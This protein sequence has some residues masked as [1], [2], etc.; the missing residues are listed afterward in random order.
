MYPTI[1]VLILTARVTAK[2]TAVI[3]AAVATCLGSRDCFCTVDLLTWSSYYNH[4][5]NP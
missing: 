3:T 1:G 5:R 2:T 4:I